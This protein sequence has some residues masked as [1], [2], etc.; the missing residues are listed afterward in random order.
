M[1][2][3]GPSLALTRMR[4]I[5]R[6]DLL[7][8]LGVAGLLPAC[9]RDEPGAIGPLL[10]PADLAARMND[11]KGGK[12]AVFYVG[13]SALFGRGHVPGARATGEIDSAEGRRALAD[14]I[15]KL[16]AETEVVVY[17]GCCPVRSC[18]NVRPASAAIRGRAKASVLDL[19]TRFATDW[20]EKGYP[21]ER[22]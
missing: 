13:P 6:R 5:K 1:N 10:P 18:P 19:P 11:V 2:P 8:G 3:R 15:A 7:V 14:A 12:I 20:A 21:V 16:P 17:C 22:S 9:T 4:T